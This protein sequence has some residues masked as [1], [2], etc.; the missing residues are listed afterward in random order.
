MTG[1][2]DFRSHSES[3]PFAN[4]PLFDHSK[5]RLVRISDPNWNLILTCS[6]SDSLLPKFRRLRNGQAA[7]LPVASSLG[8]VWTAD[9]SAL[10]V[11]IS[12]FSLSLS[13]DDEWE[14]SS[15]SLDAEEDLSKNV[16]NDFWNLG[17][18][19]STL[20]HAEVHYINCRQFVAS[21]FQLFSGV[22]NVLSR[23]WGDSRC[24]TRVCCSTSKRGKWGESG[25]SDK[26]NDI[27]DN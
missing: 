17:N 5:T 16:E 4:H 11:D 8:D 14:A 18:Q 2:L 22:V 7:S 13:D 3:W 23:D 25:Y 1:F 27:Y 10:F 6:S 9:N 19:F 21:V 24:L 12:S 20:C 15:S 26:I